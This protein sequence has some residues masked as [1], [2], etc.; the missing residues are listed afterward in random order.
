MADRQAV[1]SAMA[2]LAADFDD[3]IF[4]SAV[5]SRQGYERASVCGDV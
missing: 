1:S 3:G 5:A 4:K 2:P